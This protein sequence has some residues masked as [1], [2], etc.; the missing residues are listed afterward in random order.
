MLTNKRTFNKIQS[1]KAIYDYLSEHKDTIVEYVKGDISP[2]MMLKSPDK[3][4][5]ATWPCLRLCI[6]LD[7]LSPQS[8]TMRFKP[9]PNT[10]KIGDHMIN[11][12]G[13]FTFRC[14][15]WKARTKNNL[16]FELHDIESD[17]KKKSYN[18]K[19]FKI[20]KSHDD[21]VFKKHKVDNDDDDDHNDDDHNNNDDDQKAQQPQPQQSQQ[22]PQ[23]P[24]EYNF[25]NEAELKKIALDM[26]IES[27]KDSA[28]QA[29]FDFYTKKFAKENQEKEKKYEANITQL[30]N[31]LSK[32]KN[33]RDEIMKT[34]YETGYR[35]GEKAGYKK[36][37]LT[38]LTVTTPKEIES[39]VEDKLK[40]F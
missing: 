35:N 11:E 5:A 8:I 16:I 29:A 10:N 14:S 18:F 21:F 37:S 40:D 13:Y 22:Q 1:G 2:S 6:S 24:L 31:E 39:A 33:D 15:L 17:T 34:N 19:K 26:A 7:H 4:M 38:F 23:P 25:N 32:I 20:T 30:K 28:K 9:N 36:G 12:E 3:G 27:V